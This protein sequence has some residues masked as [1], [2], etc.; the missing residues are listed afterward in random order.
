MPLEFSIASA[1]DVTDTLVISFLQSI[2]SLL[3][4]SCEAS[5]RA[6]PPGGEHQRKASARNGVAKADHHRKPS[7]RP[8]RARCN[9]RRSEMR[10]CARSCEESTGSIGSRAHACAWWVC[11]GPGVTR[12]PQRCQCRQRRNGFEGRRHRLPSSSAIRIERRT[13]GRWTELVRIDPGV[14]LN[15]RCAPG[16]QLTP[17]E[18]SGSVPRSSA[19]PFQSTWIPMQKSRNADSR[20]MIVVPVA[21]IASAMR[22]EY[23]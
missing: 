15:G 16:C 4:A 8:R 22:D 18:P 1:L 20:T 6:A 2:G 3:R 7:A 9:V 11:R 12:R 21:P 13:P 19:A 10:W 5:G 23:R 17:A 14:E